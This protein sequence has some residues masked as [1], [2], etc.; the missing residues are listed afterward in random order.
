MEDQPTERVARRR[1][2]ARG[3]AIEPAVGAVLR[4][5]AAHELDGDAL[6]E[7]RMAGR[8][9]D[10]HPTLAKHT[11]DSY[12]PATIVPGPGSCGGPKRTAC[13]LSRF[14]CS[15]P[16]SLPSPARSLRSQRPR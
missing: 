2:H 12:F 11:L 5:L 7:V 13:W 3:M 14:P 8:D 10:A 16:E 15:S 4:H 9:D 1:R 6:I